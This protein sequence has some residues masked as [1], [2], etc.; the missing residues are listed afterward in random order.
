M[1]VALAGLGLL[2]AAVVGYSVWRYSPVEAAGRSGAGAAGVSDAAAPLDLVAS[3]VPASAPLRPDYA[4]LLAEVPKGGR[5]PLSK[6]MT[7]GIVFYGTW[8]DAMA[9]VERTG[10]PVLLHFGSPRRPT[11][12]VCVPGTW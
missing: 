2:A 1:K 12:S 8:E 4:S 7:T 11:G 3:A 9:E 10:K 5:D 6:P